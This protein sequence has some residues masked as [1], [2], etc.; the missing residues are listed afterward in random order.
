MKKLTISMIFMLT[1]V[2]PSFADFTLDDLFVSGGT[3]KPTQS[4]DAKEHD[5]H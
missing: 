3:D 1:L 4:K 5:C 2:S